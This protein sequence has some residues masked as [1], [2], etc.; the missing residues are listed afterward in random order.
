M[1][2]SHYSGALWIWKTQILSFRLQ[3]QGIPEVFV[4]RMDADIRHS[5]VHQGF[6]LLV[7]STDSYQQAFC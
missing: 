6:H 7:P 2:T 3:L 4:R 1:W 5:N